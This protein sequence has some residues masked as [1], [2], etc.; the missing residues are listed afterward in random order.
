MLEAIKMAVLQANPTFCSNLQ[1]G[2]GGIRT[3]GTPKGSA[4]FKS[5][6]FSRSATSPIYCY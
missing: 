1:N 5:A 3:P 4:D 6:A 2:E